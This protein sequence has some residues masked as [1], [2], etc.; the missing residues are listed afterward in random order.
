VA[1]KAR[2]TE[3]DFFDT[4]VHLFTLKMSF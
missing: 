3:L 1:T 4:E 2:D